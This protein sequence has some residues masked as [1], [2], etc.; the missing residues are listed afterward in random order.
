M[1]SHKWRFKTNSQFTA[2]KVFIRHPRSPA[3]TQFTG[4]V[5]ISTPEDTGPAY[6]QMKLQTARGPLDPLTTAV[7]DQPP[8]RAAKRFFT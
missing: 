3:H 7:L 1:G 6:T 5:F 8:G 4:K 2:G